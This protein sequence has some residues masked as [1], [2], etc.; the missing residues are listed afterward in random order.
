MQI[1][2][3]K[4]VK[5]IAFPSLGTGNLG[6]PNAVV[7]RVML[8]EIFKYL[9]DHKKTSISEVNLVI[10]M[11]D[12]LE[13][14]RRELKSYG[15]KETS[16]GVKKRRSIY[17]ETNSAPKNDDQTKSFVIKAVTVNISHGDI[18]ESKCDVIVNPTDSKIT[19]TGQGVAGAILR[20]GGDELKQLCDVL[21]SNGKILDDSTPVIETKAT[22][23]LKAKCLFH[24]C[25]DGNDQKSFH[26]IIMACLEKAE[27][28]QHSSIAFPAIGTGVHGYPEEQA[29]M[30]ML[31]VISQFTLKYPTSLLIIDI[32]LYQPSTFEKFIQ[33][34]QNPAYSE[35]GIF[36]RAKN[37]ILKPFGYGELTESDV[38]PLTKPVQQGE[39]DIKVY[40]LSEEAMK[41]AEKKFFHLMDEFF[42]TESIFDPMINNLSEEDKQILKRE[43][44]FKNVEMIFD[45]HPVNQI[46]LKGDTAKVHEMKNIVKD[47]LSK[48]EQ[49]ASRRRE[50]KQLSQTI[51]WK[52]MDSQESEYDEL[53]NYEIECEYQK[54]KSGQYVHGKDDPTHFIVNFKE[55][56]EVDFSDGRKYEV[57][58]LDIVEQFKKGACVCVCVCLCVCVCVCVCV[59]CM[60]SLTTMSGCTLGCKVS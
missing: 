42:T 13:S 31:K 10:Y 59:C 46:R 12:T 47:K 49:M 17:V 22:G 21:T 44:H 8:K 27:K 38:I 45:Y 43:S 54:D 55:M 52:R 15:P 53:T 51:Q 40:G 7:A 50:A 36:Q 56:L 4:G 11:K 60:L 25:F 41:N 20:K 26:K 39:L 58:R 32:V 16:K 2:G 1:C 57:V 3:D 9:S 29:A 5:S 24:I 37:F 35:S 34:F 14:F 33:A 28:E 48:M 19:L 18:T 6:F 23:S 30:G